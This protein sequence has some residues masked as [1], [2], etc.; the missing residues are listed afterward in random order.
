MFYAFSLKMQFL[1]KTHSLVEDLLLQF[2]PFH[3][4]YDMWRLLCAKAFSVVKDSVLTR[5]GNSFIP[6]KVKGIQHQLVIYNPERKWKLF[7]M[8]LFCSESRI[9]NHP[10]ECS[11]N[12]RTS[13]TKVYKSWRAFTACHSWTYGLFHGMWWQSLQV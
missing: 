8:L 3:Y 13:N 10:F 9:L 12:F 1:H 2:L 7:P 6:D 11:R 4:Q 5:K